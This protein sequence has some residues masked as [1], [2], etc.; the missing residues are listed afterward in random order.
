M[1]I[2]CLLIFGG[3][4]AVLVNSAV[5]LNS[6]RKTLEDYSSFKMNSLRMRDI[7]N[8]LS[9][10]ARLFIITGDVQYAETYFNEKNS[11]HDRKDA[12]Q[13]I[14]ELYKDND[15]ETK[16]SAAAFSQ[17]ENLSAIESVQNILSGIRVASCA[18]MVNTLI[19][20][21]KAGIKDFIGIILFIAV[22]LASLIFGISPAWAV[23]AAIFVGIFSEKPWK[24]AEK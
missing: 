6:F 3:L 23:L 15:I 21:G 24:E 1:I 20:L 13:K 10:Q 11:K 12:M 7:S 5:K 22:F 17:M 16:K 4:I 8:Y 18:M 14:L 9:D 2:T 19:K